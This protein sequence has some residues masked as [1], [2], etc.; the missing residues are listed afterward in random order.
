[1][2]IEDKWKEELTTIE[3]MTVKQLAQ[4]PP[5]IKTR[6]EY[7]YETEIRK[8]MEVEPLL[9]GYVAVKFLTWKERDY[10]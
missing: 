7:G 2:K 9:D 10:Q 8:I 5:V 1:M 4:I 3:T 6:S